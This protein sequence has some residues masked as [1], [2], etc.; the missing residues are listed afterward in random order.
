MTDPI[1]TAAE[2]RDLVVKHY[3]KSEQADDPVACQTRIALCE[4][5]ALL[6]GT[7]PLPEALPVGSTLDLLVERFSKYMSHVVV[8]DGEGHAVSKPVHDEIERLRDLPK[9]I[10]LGARRRWWHKLT[11]VKS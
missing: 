1:L 8:I 7:I 10:S 5:A 6:D 11:K 9:L 2:I 3:N 4:Y